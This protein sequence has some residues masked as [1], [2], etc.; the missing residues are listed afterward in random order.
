MLRFVFK[1][2]LF[3]ILLAVFLEMFF[4]FVVPASSYPE[5]IQNEEFRVMQYNQKGPTTGLYTNGRRAEHRAHWRVNNMGWIS[6]EDYSLKDKKENPRAVIVGNSYVEAVYL[7]VDK[8]LA[9][10][11]KSRLGSDADIYTLG[12]WG[13]DLS[14]GINVVDYA[15][16]M[17]EPDLVVLVVSHGSLRRSARNFAKRPLCL[18]VGFDGGVKTEYPPQMFGPGRLGK[19][20]KLSALIR[21]VRVN[22]RLALGGG[23]QEESATIKK[24]NVPA[25]AANE[26]VETQEIMGKTA[27]WI[28]EQLKTRNP[29]TKFLLLVDADRNQI[30][31]GT[32]PLPIP[33]SLYVSEAIIGEEN[34][35]LLDLTEAF[36][37][38]HQESGLPLHSVGNYHWNEYAVDVIAKTLSKFITEKEMLAASPIN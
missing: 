8:H 23:A 30:Q 32:E 13:V 19:I 1:T 3:L 2:G 9:P 36:W 37:S 34:F 27:A 16:E 22:A 24:K 35:Y 26:L 18:Q 31:E 5:S 14:Q 38:A 11:T 33:A 25:T 15:R 6:A 17:L 20:L 28:V 21:Y 29:D 7:D 4:R 10:V 12:A